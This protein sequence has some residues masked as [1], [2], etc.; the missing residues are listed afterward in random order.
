MPTF[1]TQAQDEE[2]SRLADAGHLTSVSVEQAQASAHYTTQ[3][4]M[5]FDTKEGQNQPV[6]LDVSYAL[7]PFSYSDFSLVL[8][9]FLRWGDF[10]SVICRVG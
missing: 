8:L 4:W 10:A 3:I 2:V 9:Q 7:C 1:L 6:L 5:Q